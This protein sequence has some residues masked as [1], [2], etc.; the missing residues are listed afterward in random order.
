MNSQ[1]VLQLGMLALIIALFSQRFLHPSGLI[2]ENAIDAVNGFLIGI[3][4]GLNLLALVL[5]RR[6]ERCASHQ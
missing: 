3:S 6:T 4:I 1:R 5:G 2:G